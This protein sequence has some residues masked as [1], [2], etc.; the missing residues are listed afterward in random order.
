MSIQQDKFIEIAD[1]I[2]THLGHENA[3]VPNSFPD[4]IDKVRDTAYASGDSNGYQRG[5]NEGYSAGETEGYNSGYQIGESEGYGMGYEEGREEGYA[6]GESDGYSTGYKRGETDGYN[7]GFEAGK[8]AAESAGGKIVRGCWTAS[9][10]KSLITISGVGFK[11]K[12]VRMYAIGYAGD[13]DY[14]VISLAWKASGA[15]EWSA[16]DKSGQVFKNGQRAISISLTAMDD[17]FEV[18]TPP[19]SS[20][21]IMF[22]SKF[23]YVWEAFEEEQD[24]WTA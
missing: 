1:K 23:P 21:T 14:Y 20:K 6:A 2:R 5:H 8:V 7:T 12:E 22:N 4:E 16:E 15:F 10:D 24:E 19:S 13:Y 3:I 17:G 18:L 11:P 9:S